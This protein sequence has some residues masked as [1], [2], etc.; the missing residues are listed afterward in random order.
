MLRPE[1]FFFFVKIYSGTK[2]FYVKQLLVTKMSGAQKIFK[3]VKHFLLANKLLESKK[4]LES[5]ILWAEIFYGAKRNFFGSYYFVVKHFLG[6]NI[7]GSEIFALKL[8]WGVL[9]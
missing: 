7:L 6:P 3:G 5:K 4:V 1:F 9:R 2:F 8:F